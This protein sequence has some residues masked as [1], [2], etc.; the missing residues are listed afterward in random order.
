MEKLLLMP[1]S[2]KLASDL[3]VSAPEDPMQ[4]MQSLVLMTLLKVVCNLPPLLKYGGNPRYKLL[5]QM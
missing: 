2:I 5:T 3:Y 1:L 4:I